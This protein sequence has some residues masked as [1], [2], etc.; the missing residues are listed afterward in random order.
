MIFE[1]AGAVVLT[2]FWMKEFDLWH[3]AYLGIFHSVSAF[4]TAGFSIFSNNFM[5]YSTS[6]TLN[7]SINIISIIGG[8]G[9]FVLIDLYNLVYKKSKNIYPRKLTVHSK[10]VILVTGIVMLSG[11]IIIFL[12]KKWPV[13]MQVSERIMVSFFQSISASTTDGFN[14]IDIGAMSTTGLT[15]LMFL[16]FVGASPGSTGGGMKTTTLATLFIAVKSYLQGK[17]EVN[18]I[19]KEIPQKSVLKALV[20]FSIFV[21]ILLID[22]LVLSY[23]EDVS[24]IR[25][26]FETVSALG[27]TGLSTGITS[28]LSF[29]G[30]IVLILTM[31]I[32]RV[33]PLTLGIALLKKHDPALYRHTQED[34]F[35]G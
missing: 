19:G 18:I 11:A 22:M 7:M 24:Y 4:C 21:L 32:G 3:A 9:F 23:T 16:M 5:S 13:E 26:L 34:I 1:F 15:M 25:I 27:N 31:F 10:M 17:K 8:L 28:N 12:S 14:S 20:V 30:K 35:I 29:V 2:A 6:T 33:G